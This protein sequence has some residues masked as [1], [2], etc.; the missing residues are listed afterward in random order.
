MNK[1]GMLRAALI[2]GALCLLAVF[3]LAH[4]GGRGSYQAASRSGYDNGYLLGFNHGQYDRNHRAGYNSECKDCRQADHG[5]RSSYGDRGRYQ[6]GFRAAFQLGYRDGFDGR[7]RR[8]S[9]FGGFNFENGYRGSGFRGEFAFGYSN[10]KGYHAYGDRSGY[11]FDMGRRKGYEKGLEKG[12]K[13]FEKGRNFDLNRHD[14]YR[15]ADDG[16]HSDYGNKAVY[17]DGFR[18]GFEEGYREGYGGQYRR[19]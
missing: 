7:P 18:R 3:T 14:A 19:Y 5:Y 13:D 6:E 1:Q 15:D 4:D 12:R 10:G 17:R 8:S 2:L 16:Y 11:A 9:Y